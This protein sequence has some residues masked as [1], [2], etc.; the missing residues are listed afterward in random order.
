MSE[1]FKENI[2]G[3]LNYAPITLFGEKIRIGVIGAG[4]GALIKVRNFYN[5][6]SNIEVLSLDFLADF[7]KFNENKVKLIKGS[8]NKDFILDKHLIIIAID[9]ESVIN[10]IKS[11][12]EELFK[13]YIN[14]SKFRE[15]M[16][17]IPVT[18]ESEFITVAVNT[19][20]GNPRGSVMVANSITESLQEFDEYINLTGKI[21]NCL[22]LDKEIK[23]DL[24]KFINSSD[25]KFFYSKNKILEVFRLFYND[26]I[27]SKIKSLRKEE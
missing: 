16:G 11:D 13:I 25:C 20:V 4:R 15:G 17:V 21:R 6:G 5:K 23:D 27:V 10:K 26:D 3:E 14:S 22:T 7:Y 18:R 9:D 8:Y 2:H 19:K 12:C 1:Y 24:L